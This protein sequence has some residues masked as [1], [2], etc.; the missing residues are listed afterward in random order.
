MSLEGTVDFRGFAE[1]V[2]MHFHQA[3]VGTPGGESL[4]L[5]QLSLPPSLSIVRNSN[6]FNQELPAVPKYLRTLRFTV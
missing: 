2:C 5:T 1:V 4:Q 6:L 3:P